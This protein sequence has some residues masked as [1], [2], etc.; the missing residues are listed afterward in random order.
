MNPPNG[1]LI[2]EC[3]LFYAFGPCFVHYFI[4]SLIYFYISYP[5][6]FQITWSKKVLNFTLIRYRKYVN[7]LLQNKCTQFV[8]YHPKMVY[9]N[10]TNE[11]VQD[12]ESVSH[13]GC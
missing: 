2:E 1:P 10:F 11:K 9:D 12:V 6:L 7:L 5:F 4:C 13:V 8:K 3:V